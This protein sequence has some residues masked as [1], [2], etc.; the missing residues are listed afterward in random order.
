MAVDSTKVIVPGGATLYLG[1][2]GATLS[3]FNGTASPGTAW[4]DA[5]YLTEDGATFELARTTQDITVW[6]SLDPV[7][8]IQQ[9]LTKTVSMVLREWSPVN[10]KFVLGGGTVTA[11]TGTAGGT[12]YGT[13]NMPS[14]SE[15]TSIAVVLD[16]LDGSY[17]TR[18]Y[19]PLMVVGD[20]V[21]IPVSR[22]DSMTLP[23]S[24]TSLASATAT[25][26]YSNGPGWT[27]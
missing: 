21:S 22:N 20:N 11:G 25:T 9:T 26:I 1:A 14:P 16:C 3:A 10:L 2:T 18:F 13:Y 27:A 24:V 4:T 5:G 7:R 23:F 17:S 8:K 15:N 6:Q 12:A 19:F